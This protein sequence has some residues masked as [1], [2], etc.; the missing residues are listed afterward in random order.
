MA[1]SVSADAP[2]P[3]RPRPPWYARVGALLGLIWL[4]CYLEY[5]L[6]IGSTPIDR[7]IVP[8]RLEDGEFSV[9]FAAGPPPN[10]IMLLWPFWGIPEAWRYALTGVLGIALYAAI[11]RYAPV[12]IRSRLGALIVLLFLIGSVGLTYVNAYLMFPPH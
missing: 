2:R 5:G 3:L 7:W 11:I 9:I 1:P 12:R 10:S 8:G 6:A 4:A